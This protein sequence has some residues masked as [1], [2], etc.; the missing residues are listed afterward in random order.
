MKLM[1]KISNN[2]LI[3]HFWMMF[4]KNLRSLKNH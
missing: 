4:R 1:M 2:I 3:N